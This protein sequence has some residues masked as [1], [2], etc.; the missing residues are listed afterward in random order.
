MGD[1][2]GLVA[3]AAAASLSDVKYSEVKCVSGCSSAELASG[4]MEDLSL[5]MA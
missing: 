5:A 1:P 2:S 4:G 3:P